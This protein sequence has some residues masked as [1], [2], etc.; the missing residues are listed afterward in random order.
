MLETASFFVVALSAVFVVVD[1]IAT[2]PIFAS[3]T[4]SMPQ[5]DVRSVARRGTVVGAALLV[6][7]TMFGGLLFR[8]LHVELGAFRV[9]GGILLLLT[10]LDMLRA[11]LPEARCTTSEIAQGSERDDVAIVP[12]ATPL[13]AGPGAMATVMMLTSERQGVVSVAAVLAAVALT[14]AATYV[15]LVS[16]RRVTAALGRSGSAILQRVMGLVLAAIAIQFVAD[17]GKALL[18]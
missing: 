10:S 8:M 4:S 15:V 3:L 11:R 17:G 13:L 12:V 14:F 5:A 9:A 1:P 2:A 18:G 7:F 16:A 6:F